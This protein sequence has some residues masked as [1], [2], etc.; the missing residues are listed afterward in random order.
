MKK[1]VRTVCQ[2]CHCECGVLATVTDGR[3]TNI[4]GD[5]AH[6]MN[7]G[8]CCIK[9]KAQ[10]ELLYHPH[11]LKYPLRRT[12]DRGSGQWTRVSWDQALEEVADKL[13]EVKERYGP[14]SIATIH[15]TGPRATIPASELLATSLGTPNIIS[16]DG[17]ICFMPSI[18]AERAT[19]G[20]VI[21]M[22]TGP[23]YEQTSCILVWGAN[24]LLSHPPRGREIIR[25]KDKRGA[26]LIVIDPRR[27]TLA[28][29]ADLWL[30]VRPGTDAALALGMLNTIVDEGLYAHEF[31]D[32]WCHGFEQLKQHLM[33]Y[34][35]Q[36][37]AEICWVPA[38]IIRAAARLYA[39][40][41]PAALH[42]RVALEQ[43]IN[44]TQTMRAII[45]LVALTGNI[46]IPGGNLFP[47]PS[48]GFASTFSILSSIVKGDLRLPPEIAAKRIGAREYPLYSGS[49]SVT[50]FAHSP[51]SLEAI[52]TGK[53]YPIKALYCGGANPAINMQNTRRVWGG[54]KNLDLLVVADLFM[55]PTAEMADYVLPV[56]SWLE[57]DGCCE[58]MYLN[59]LSARQKVIEPLYECWD[60]MKI[61][62]ELSK[63]IA[64]ADRK[65]LPW[66][67]VDQWNEYRVK[68]MDVTFQEF[69]QQ[70]CISVPVSYRRYATGGFE[71]PS[72]KVELYSTIFEKHGYDPLPSFKEPSESPVSTPDLL[73]DYP[74]I[75][76]TGARY[77]GYFHSEGRQLPSLRS[78][79]PDPE[80]EIHPDTAAQRHI[81]EGD[82][83][84][85]E[86]PRVKGERVKLRAKLTDSVDQ[87]MVHAAHAWWFPEQ[88]E[89]EHGCFD[90][91]VNVVLSG[92]SPRD[93][94]CGSVPTRGTL[95][96]V[97]PV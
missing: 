22:E 52:V 37:V 93:E 96:Q 63:R 95:C 39:T 7:R 55:T 94:I 32:K 44:S 12:G 87:R 56:A 16:I 29:K 24:P 43:N 1:I 66:D 61:A 78:L 11:R 5:P 60:D 90:S 46:D 89:P 73:E 34:P 92:D 62:I 71:T 80:I 81:L 48:V 3:I 42:S 2:S 53:P 27:T 20:S 59:Y 97:Y 14:E 10:L 54:L 31:V 72:G 38:D 19:I 35:P 70:G 4:A 88:P 69:K 79:T 36:K 65:C 91:N 82:W 51:L 13:T 47:M 64:W 25:A 26:K 84:W 33:D 18:I 74:L 49:E 77:M 23:D 41:K 68:G 28:E 17:H 75:L 30:Q 45:S 15:G 6:P 8:Y 86:T 40:T 58:T 9:G 50:P 21:T 85:L 83:V 57:R 67:D 76:C